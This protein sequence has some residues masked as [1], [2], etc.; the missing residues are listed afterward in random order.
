MGIPWL[1]LSP[2]AA[3]WSLSALSAK[4]LHYYVLEKKA[5]EENDLRNNFLE[6]LKLVKFGWIYCTAS[7]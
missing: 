6:I 3:G 5:A 7:G 2:P 4:N 1:Y